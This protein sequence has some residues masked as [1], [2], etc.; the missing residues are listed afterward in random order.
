MNLSV[1]LFPVIC[2]EDTGITKFLERYYSRAETRLPVSFA[3]ATISRRIAAMRFVEP[4]RGREARDFTV[5]KR[6]L[7]QYATLLSFLL[8]TYAVSLSSYVQT[9]SANPLSE[10]P[11]RL[12]HAFCVMSALPIAALAYSDKNWRSSDAAPIC[13]GAW[14]IVSVAL[15]HKYAIA[16]PF[17]V[18]FPFLPFLIS[19]VIAHAAGKATQFLLTKSK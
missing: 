2:G 12:L 15:V 9:L 17:T 16:C 6:K 7:L 4:C 11:I 8:L 5:T 10:P 14:A 13:V 3:V 1:C 19:A 18:M